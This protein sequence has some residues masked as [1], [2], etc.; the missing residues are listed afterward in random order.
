M[1][2]VAV[3]M[4]RLA[5]LFPSLPSQTL[6]QAGTLAR[7]VVLSAFL[8]ASPAQAD[9]NLAG[10]GTVEE[11][12][13]KLGRSEVATAAYAAGV[14]AMGNVFTECKNPRT[15]RELHAYLL[16]RALSTLT[17]K[18][19]IWNFLIEADCTMMSEGR[20]MSA[21]LPQGKPGST[22]DGEY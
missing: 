5:I 19:A 1:N 17:M 3:T 20:F 4:S 9:E 11:W 15:V 7:L 2:P 8:L 13:A 21:N 14:M 10:A 22:T 6:V 12:R 18:Q 16:Y